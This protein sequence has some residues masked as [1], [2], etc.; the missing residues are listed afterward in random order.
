MRPHLLQNGLILTRGRGD[1]DKRMI[2]RR[3]T[4]HRR[5]A[6]VDVLHRVVDGDDDFGVIL[7]SA[8]K[9]AC[10]GGEGV[11]VFSLGGPNGGS[12]EDPLLPPPPR[13]ARNGMRASGARS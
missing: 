6:D 4:H 13:R 10:A 3:R 5:A 11:R 2:L 1:R 8:M 9:G 7:G 12:L